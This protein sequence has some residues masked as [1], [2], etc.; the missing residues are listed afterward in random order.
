MYVDIQYIP[1]NIGQIFTKNMTPSGI[2]GEIY[3]LLKLSNLI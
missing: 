1:V 2:S 3:N